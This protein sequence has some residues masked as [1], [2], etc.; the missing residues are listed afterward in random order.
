MPG[1]EGR[2]RGVGGSWDSGDKSS[3]DGGQRMVCAAAEHRGTCSVR[4]GGAARCHQPEPPVTLRFGVN[5]HSCLGQ[6]GCTQS[7]KLHVEG[8]G[9]VPRCP[10]DLNPSLARA[11]CGRALSVRLSSKTIGALCSL[12]L[13]HLLSGTSGQVSTGNQTYA[14]PCLA[15]DTLQ[16]CLRS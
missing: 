4:A 12:T 11:I 14:P 6:S 3:S 16:P 5:I 2:S 13:P 7:H 15:L 8:L 10:P 1:V 9:R